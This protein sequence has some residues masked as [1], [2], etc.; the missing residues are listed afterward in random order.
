MQ[1]T[2]YSRH[3]FIREVLELTKQR[4]MS[5]VANATASKVTANSSSTS[6][7]TEFTTNAN[8]AEIFLGVGYILVIIVFLKLI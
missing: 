6:L 5:R 8:I 2:T 1:P 7:S 4:M 3:Q